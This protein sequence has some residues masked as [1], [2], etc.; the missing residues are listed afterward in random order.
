MDPHHPITLC[1]AQ[2][3]SEMSIHMDSVGVTG[4]IKNGTYECFDRIYDPC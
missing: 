3:A 2:F 4:R 1:T